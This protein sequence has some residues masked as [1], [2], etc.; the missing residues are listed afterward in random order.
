MKTSLTF[1]FVLYCVYSL[2]EG[3]VT[4]CYNCQSPNCRGFTREKCPTS[5][6]DD[7]ICISSSMVLSGRVYQQKTC[8]VRTQLL[9]QN[10]N[11]VN[12]L[13]GHCYI[14]EEDLCNR[15]W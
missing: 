8:N 11:T 9:E 1:V 13:G 14:C 15:A 4:E 3:G 2:A 10:C 7:N 5:F 6:S 12:R